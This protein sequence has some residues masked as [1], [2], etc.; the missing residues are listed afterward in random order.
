MSPLRHCCVS[1]VAKGSFVTAR[2]VSGFLMHVS[3]HHACACQECHFEGLLLQEP[4]S[5]MTQFHQA[6]TAQYQ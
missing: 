2:A 1:I 6:I 5:K 4:V 3:I